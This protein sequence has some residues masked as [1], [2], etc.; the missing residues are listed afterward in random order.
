MAMEKVTWG[1]TDFDQFI[2]LVRIAYAP[3][4]PLARGLKCS[5]YLH[6]HIL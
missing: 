4:L 3:K 5:Q 6:L 2:L 1:L